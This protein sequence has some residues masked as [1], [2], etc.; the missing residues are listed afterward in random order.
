MDITVREKLCKIDLKAV[1]QRALA[2]APP[3]DI[4][5][6]ATLTNSAM[7]PLYNLYNHALMALPFSKEILSFLWTKTVNKTFQKRRLVAKNKKLSA[8]FGMGSLQ[9]QH[10][11]KTAEGLHIN[12]VQKYFGKINQGVTTKPTHILESMLQCTGRPSL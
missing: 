5:L 3:T 6:K 8:S 11:E 12:Q 2:T 10:T 7:T 1:K 9:I 4:Q